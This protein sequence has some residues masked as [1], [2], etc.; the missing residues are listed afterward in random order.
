MGEL[1]DRIANVLDI[2]NKVVAERDGLA[3][4]I[5][6]EHGT[7][8]VSYPDLARILAARDARIAVKAK[9]EVLHEAAEY[10]HNAGEWVISAHLKAMANSQEPK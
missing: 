7:E 2:Y 1:A 9:R 6:N 5:A 3:A 10:W 4:V 8:Y